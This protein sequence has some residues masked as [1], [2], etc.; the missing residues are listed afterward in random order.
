MI[1]LVDSPEWVITFI[2]AT[3]M[4]K[5]SKDMYSIHFQIM[6][7]LP[8]I[9]VAT[10]VSTSS[11]TLTPSKAEKF[12]PCS[13][14]YQVIACKVDRLGEGKIRINWRDGKKMTYY[15]S[16][17]NNNYLRDSLGGDWRYLDF[18]VGKAFSLTNSKNRNVIICNGTFREYGK[19]V[20]L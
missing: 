1:R 14:N 3:A 2:A 17:R 15:G 7:S 6:K 12:V 13:F 18:D 11:I 8:A 16:L 20:G 19:Y 10:L 4:M 5:W 9:C